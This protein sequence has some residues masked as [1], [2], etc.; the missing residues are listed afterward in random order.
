MIGAA[1]L[2]DGATQDDRSLG[3]VDWSSIPNL[4]HGSKE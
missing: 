1:K 2:D 4:H 3:G